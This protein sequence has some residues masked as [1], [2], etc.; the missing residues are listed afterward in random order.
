MIGGLAE[1]SMFEALKPTD[2][3][4]D[5]KELEDMFCQPEKVVEKVEKPSTEFKIRFFQDAFLCFVSS[6][7]FLLY[8]HYNLVNL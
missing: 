3:K 5:I 6:L 1:G 2:I 4:L 8:C 7:D